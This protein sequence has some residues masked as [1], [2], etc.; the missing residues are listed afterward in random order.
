MITELRVDI[1]RPQ[2]MFLFH[3]IY[4]S[5]RG[6]DPPLLSYTL[7]IHLQS[8]HRHDLHLQAAGSRA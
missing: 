1:A 6:R 8:M 5:F 7:N 2:R 3:L 4:C